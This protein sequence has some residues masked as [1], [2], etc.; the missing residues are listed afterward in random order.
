MMFS[1]GFASI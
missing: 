1:G